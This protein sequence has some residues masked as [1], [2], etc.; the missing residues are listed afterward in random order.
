[1][2]VFMLSKILEK[3][4]HR[5][6]EPAEIA[7]NG[8]NPW[9]IQVH[10]RRL[11]RR[12]FL[13]G[14]LGFGEAYMDGWWDCES[15]DQLFCRLVK[16]RMNSKIRLRSISGAIG[17]ARSALVNMQEIA[18]SEVA[19]KHYDIGNRL[20]ERMLDPSMNYSCGYWKNAD[21]LEQAQLDK[22]KL[23]CE[24][25]MLEPGMKVLDIGCGWGGLM[26]YAA[27]N[28]NVEVSGITI[29]AEQV[30]YIDQKLGDAPIKV[31]LRNY[32][33]MRGSYDRIY[34]V[35]MFEHVGHKNYYGYMEKMRELLSADGL[36]LL[37]TIGSICSS[38]DGDPWL[39]KYIFPNSKLPSVRQIAQACERFFVIEDLHNFGG[40]YERTLLAWSEN[41]KRAWPQL[42]QDY[43]QRFYRMWM[44]YLLGMA[45]TFRARYNQLWQLALS[46]SGVPGGYTASR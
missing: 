2:G 26:R 41:F 17:L 31:F 13:Y 18:S 6:L 44:Y 40:D 45:G 4:Y 37:H 35:G 16:L 43:D 25:L 19:R 5:Y 7:I 23:I 24:K 36:F 1:M 42:Q 11:Y 34:S 10:D 22:M 3:K 39:T 33:R 27:E 30:K 20:F 28:Y 29:S 12:V 21:N 15:L 9:D 14:S 8:N 38:P 32:R 46:P